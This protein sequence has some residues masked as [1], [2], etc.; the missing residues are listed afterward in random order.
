MKVATKSQAVKVG[1][2][3]CFFSLQTANLARSTL[4]EPDQTGKI[5]KN[6]R[7]FGR[8]TGLGPRFQIVS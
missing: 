7:F 4:S 5:T 6:H 2:L 3:G 8:E 1:N